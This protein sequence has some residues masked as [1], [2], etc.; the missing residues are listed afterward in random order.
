MKNI[1]FP[2]FARKKYCADQ[3]KSNDKTQLRR[4]TSDKERLFDKIRQLEISVGAWKLNNGAAPQESLALYIT[5]NPRS[6]KMATELMGKKC[7]DLMHAKNYNLQAE[8]MTCIQKSKSRS[9][10]VDFDIDDKE[11]DLDETWLKNEVGEDNY[12]IIE[13]RG[14]YHILIEPEKATDFRQQKYNDKNW[15]QKV[16]KKYP[17]D[18]SGDQLIPV[19]GTFQGGFIPKFIVK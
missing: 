9:C 11:I 14:G 15:Y 13:T 17:V 10:Y 7:W 12:T 18:Q 19:V 6:M 4:F 1:T 16:K 2:F 5:I 8:A 3:I